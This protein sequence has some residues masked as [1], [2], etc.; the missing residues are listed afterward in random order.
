MTVL[1][2]SSVC[3]QAQVANEGRNCSGD[4]KDLVFSVDRSTVRGDPVVEIVIGL[5]RGVPPRIAQAMW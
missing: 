3:R 5:L 1:K 4:L 2:M